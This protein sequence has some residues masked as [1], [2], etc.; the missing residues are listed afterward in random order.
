MYT[1]LALQCYNLL[2]WESLKGWKEGGQVKPGRFI[3]FR[4]WNW[5]S[6]EVKT[7]QVHKTESRE[8]STAQRDRPEICSLL[9]VFSRAQ[10]LS[11]RK[12]PR[13]MKG[14]AGKDW[15]QC[16]ELKQNQNKA[17]STKIGKTCKSWD[18]EVSTQEVLVPEWAWLQTHLTNNEVNVKVWVTQ[19][20]SDSLR[21]WG[22]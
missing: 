7:F 16:L 12:L 14:S 4:R 6:G 20:V 1:R 2:P 21:P 8:E 3:E 11:V 15:R 5:A 17:C 9:W 10:H 13:A 19:G 22:L 18:I